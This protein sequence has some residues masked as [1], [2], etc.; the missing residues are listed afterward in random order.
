MEIR[1]LRYFL[2]VA[3]EG[4]FT[5]AAQTL[6]VTQPTLSRQLKEL[7]DEL[8]QKLFIRNY[9]H[10]TLTEE[11]RLLRQ[12]AQEIMEMVSKTEAD[13][14]SMGESVSGDVYIG[15]GESEAMKLIA[16]VIK[17]VQAGYPDIRFHLHSGTADDVTE[18][19]D[20]GTLDFGILIQPANMAKYDRIDL[21]AKDTWGIIMRKDSP[22][23]LKKTITSKD[24]LD[25]SLIVASR[26][27]TRKPSGKTGYSEWVG[28]D[29][30][31]LKVVATYNLIYNASLMV[32]EG[33]GCAIGLANLINVMGNG[34]LCFRPLEPKL[35]SGLSIVWKKYQVFSTAAEIFLANIREAFASSD[36]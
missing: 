30:D 10:I 26:Q 1:V 13:F 3:R 12:R 28:R 29:F 35:E 25:I 23:A 24:L 36:L 18:R 9:H 20:K 17:K 11:G 19:I 34:N 22:L 27:I 31:K 8:G 6:H 21:P 16:R 32:E 33:I 5:G 4:S 14:N 7:E 15:G 2:A